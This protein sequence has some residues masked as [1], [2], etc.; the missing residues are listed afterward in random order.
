MLYRRQLKWDE[1]IEYSKK[2]LMA[3]KKVYG[4]NHIRLAKV[5]I[6]Y[7]YSLLER[8]ADGDTKLAAEYIQE[9]LSIINEQEMSD[10]K[11]QCSDR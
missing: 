8:N 7:V 4:L 1:S 9:A 11:S 6:G 2:S 5:Y 3:A 10:D